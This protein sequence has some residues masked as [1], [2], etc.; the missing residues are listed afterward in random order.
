[1]AKSKD[2]TIQL[3][4][5]TGTGLGVGQVV[6]TN[7]I[8]SPRGAF[9]L[10]VVGGMAGMILSMDDQWEYAPIAAAYGLSVMYA[11]I[12]LGIYRGLPA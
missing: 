11:N 3:S 6:V 4:P 5:L 7:A 10:N 12:L 1:M 9:V 2:V 8:V